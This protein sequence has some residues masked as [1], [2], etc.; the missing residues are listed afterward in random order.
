MGLLRESAFL[1]FATE[2]IWIQ[3]WKYLG[4]FS[5]ALSEILLQGISDIIIQNSYF[6][7]QRKIVLQIIIIMTL[8]STTLSSDWAS[9]SFVDSLDFVTL[10]FFTSS[11]KFYLLIKYNDILLCKH[12]YMRSM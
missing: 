9:F 8:E 7:I 4:Y 6:F 11:S 1:L 5:H 3:E 2:N 12:F 10:E